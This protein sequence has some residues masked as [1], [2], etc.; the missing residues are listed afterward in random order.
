[1]LSMKLSRDVSILQ[2][3]NTL[4]QIVNKRRAKKVNKFIISNQHI[5]NESICYIPSLFAEN[6]DALSVYNCDRASCF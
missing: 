6:K 5:K 4:A 2:C 3:D 1:M